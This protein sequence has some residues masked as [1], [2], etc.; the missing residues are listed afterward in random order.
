[1]AVRVLTAFALLF[2]LRA[3][4][5]GEGGHLTMTALEIF[6]ESM[7]LQEISCCYEPHLLTH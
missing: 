2:V 5:S 4:L 6:H 3:A 7:I 1:M